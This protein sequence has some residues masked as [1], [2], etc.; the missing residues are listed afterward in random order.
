MKI[1]DM[2]FPDRPI[3]PRRD[4]EFTHEKALKKIWEEEQNLKAYLDMIKDFRALPTD[5]DED[6]EE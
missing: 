1:R 5:K 2:K 3:F 4:A 6:W